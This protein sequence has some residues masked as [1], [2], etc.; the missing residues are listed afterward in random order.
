MEK[1]KDWIQRNWYWLVIAFLVWRLVAVTSE[2]TSTPPT[3]T[4][5]STSTPWVT[6]TPI[7]LSLLSK[8]TP[9]PLPRRYV[10]G[11]WDC[12]PE[13]D[14]GQHVAVLLVYADEFTDDEIREIWREGLCYSF[15][16]RLE[17]AYERD[18]YYEWLDEQGEKGKIY[19]P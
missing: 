16:V 10:E 1:N 11:V 18:R 13:F 9:T 17:E 3:P 7:P 8:P 12:P 14:S 6:P 15:L 19:G 4:P 2:T 5:M